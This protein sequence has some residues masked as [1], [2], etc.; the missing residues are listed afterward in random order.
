MF[1]EVGKFLESR[2]VFELFKMLFYPLCV[3][4]CVSS[5][6]VLCQVMQPRELIDL[7]QM[8]WQ[9][10]IG[11][12]LVSGWEFAIWAPVYE[13]WPQLG[14]QIFLDGHTHT[15]T[16]THS[17]PHFC[18]VYYCQNL[19]PSPSPSQRIQFGNLRT[20]KK[21][22]DHLESL[23]FTIH[24]RLF[25]IRWFVLSWIDLWVNMRQKFTGKACHI[26]HAIILSYV[27]KAKQVLSIVHPFAL[28]FVFVSVCGWL[29][30]ENF[31]MRQSLKI[32]LKW[33]AESF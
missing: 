17:H 31:D 4:V 8:S 28:L 12:L 30:A 7:K 27:I 26:C 20:R 1:Y 10:L 6:P 23:Q 3:C 2:T 29:E 33:A 24:P 15:H 9:L 19:P 22:S 25:A 14:G 21:C 16:H 5:H 11:W 18:C 13:K 32:L